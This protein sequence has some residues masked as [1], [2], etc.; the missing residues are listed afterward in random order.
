MPATLNDLV[1]D[2]GLSVITSGGNRLDLCTTQPTTYT[3]ATS[4]YTAANKT[5]ITISSPGARTGGGRK[6]TIS[7]ITDGTVTSAVS[8]G[9]FAITDTVNSRLLVSGP[10]AF[11]ASLSS[12]Y[13]F[14][15]PAF[16]VGIPSPV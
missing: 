7:A 12:S 9:F 15:L 11:T 2:N 14:T 1:Y 5:G 16:D 8:V 3:E 6:V 10:L 13:P 4:T